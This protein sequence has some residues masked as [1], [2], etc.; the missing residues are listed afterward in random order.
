MEPVEMVLPGWANCAVCKYIT[1]TN[2]SELQMYITELAKTHPLSIIIDESLTYVNLM[3]T[4]AHNTKL[5]N[6]H[7]LSRKNMIDHIKYCVA[8]KEHNLR[9]IIVYCEIMQHVATAE[10]Q[11]KASAL[12]M[13]LKT[14]PRDKNTV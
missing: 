7:D 10:P 13:L 5:R 12:N 14:L 6:T 3:M 8:C 4:R 1:N 9:S 2:T 11:A